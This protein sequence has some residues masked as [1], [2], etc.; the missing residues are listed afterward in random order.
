MDSM[1]LDASDGGSAQRSRM[2][3]KHN[4]QLIKAESKRI[5]IRIRTA[6]FVGWLLRTFSKPDA[7]RP[8]KYNAFP[9][10]FNN[11]LARQNGK[12]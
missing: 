9:K 1:E 2:G 12:E 4:N 8:T 11:Q 5:R 10:R 3:N 7:N 6:A